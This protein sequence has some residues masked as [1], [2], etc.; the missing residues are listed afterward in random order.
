MH[1]RLGNEVEVVQ[2]GETSQGFPFAYTSNT[3]GGFVG[4]A[5]GIAVSNNSSVAESWWILL[6]DETHLRVLVQLRVLQE[7][8]VVV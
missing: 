6:F 1:T 7:A 8:T 2:V 4:Q 3:S 5:F